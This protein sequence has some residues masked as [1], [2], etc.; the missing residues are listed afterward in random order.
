[1]EKRERCKTSHADS[2]TDF[3]L[4][5]PFKGNLKNFSVV[6]SAHQVVNTDVVI[7]RD[8]LKGTHG[9]LCLSTLIASQCIRVKPHKL[10][11]NRHASKWPR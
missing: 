10:G 8:L 7:I 11:C 2:R 6:R 5:S 9:R 4:R 3:W 1:M